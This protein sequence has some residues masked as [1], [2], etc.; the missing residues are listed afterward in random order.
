MTKIL[1][2]TID[3]L[4]VYKVAS[5]FEIENFH[6]FESTGDEL[7]DETPELLELCQEDPE[8]PSD[9]ITEAPEAE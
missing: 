9:P 3:G 2:S 6:V 5:D 8:I 1:R 7:L 4:T